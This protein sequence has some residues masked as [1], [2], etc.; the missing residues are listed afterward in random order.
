[1]KNKPAA[2]EQGERAPL[3]IIS[4]A[5]MISLLMA[6]F[7]MLLTMAST[8]S[9]KLVNEGE[10]IFEATIF[11]FK[12]S[13]E[14]FGVPEIF[15]GKPGQYGTP[16]EALYFDSHKTYYAVKGDETTDRTID[17][18]EE[19]IRRVFNRL[20]RHATT[21]KSQLQWGQPDFVVT[22]IAFKQ[23]QY[24]LDETAVVRGR[25]RLTGNRRKTTVDSVS[26]KGRGGRRL[27][28]GQSAGRQS[29]VRIFVGSRDRGRLGGARQ[30]NSGTVADFHRDSERK[31]DP[32]L[33]SSFST[34]RRFFVSAG[35]WSRDYP[36]INAAFVLRHDICSK[37][38]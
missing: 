9:G 22:P 37:V 33:V 7:V 24:V 32:R 31:T 12:K 6:F 14:G 18:A 27:H 10:G 4:F 29:M 35:I 21:S 23:G 28:P 2:E 1:V 8:K 26:Q 36:R 34:L 38:M 13:I 19:R 15:G 20:G 11:G 30:R 17:A 25:N 16:G 3:W 5:D